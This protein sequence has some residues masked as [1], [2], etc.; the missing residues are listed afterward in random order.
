[1]AKNNEA[2]KLK[3][4]KRYAIQLICKKYPEY[5]YAKV[6]EII[7]VTPMTVSRWKGKNYFIEQ[8]RR[9]KSLMTRSIKNFLIKRCKNKFTGINKASSRRLSK[10]LKRYFNRN[11]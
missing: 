1:M 7:G 6:A 10:E 9:R 3:I 5:S 2:N 4:K 8:K 11:G